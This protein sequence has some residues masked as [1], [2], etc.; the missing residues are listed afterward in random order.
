M[1]AATTNCVWPWAMP[2]HSPGKAMASGHA[3]RWPR[4]TDERVPRNSASPTTVQT[5]N[6]GA[7][8]R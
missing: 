5:T 2:S 7:N 4:I 6:A 8:P 1:S 3:S